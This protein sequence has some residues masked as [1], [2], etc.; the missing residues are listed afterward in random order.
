MAKDKIVLA[1]SGGLDTTVAV[2]WLQEKYD[3]DVITFSTPGLTDYVESGQM[4]LLAAMLP[5]RV[6]AYP[7]VPTVHEQGFGDAYSI[8]FGA[9]VPKGTEPAIVD[10]LS[11]AFFQAMEDPEVAEVIA[12]VG[13]VP[14]RTGPADARAR[15]DQELDEFGAIMKDL[16]ITQ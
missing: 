11:T 7:D 5:D 12:N 9:F 10:K 2:P 4:K 13:V 8:W 1:F 3:A 6:P 14:N 15:M 16:G